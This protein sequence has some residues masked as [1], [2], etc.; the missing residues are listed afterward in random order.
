MNNET[1]KDF[2]I[3]IEFGDTSLTEK[4]KETYRKNIREELRKGY[5]EAR[6]VVDRNIKV[7]DE[8]REMVKKMIEE[9]SWTLKI[10]KEFLCDK[11][12]QDIIGKPVEHMDF[13][14]FA[15]CSKKCAELF[16]Q[17]M[18][19]QQDAKAEARED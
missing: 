13:D 19:E 11:C 12:K 15:F 18:S 17:D 3:I 5:Q 8:K 10:P 9:D 16:F 6:L 1:S 2:G 14:E 4:Q 7:S